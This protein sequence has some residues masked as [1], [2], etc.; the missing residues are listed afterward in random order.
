MVGSNVW[1]D[2]FRGRVGDTKSLEF[3]R[4]RWLGNEARC[5]KFP[6]LYIRVEKK[7]VKISY[8]DFWRGSVWN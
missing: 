6:N 5:F 3:W 1:M 4:S 2:F 7:N 8:L